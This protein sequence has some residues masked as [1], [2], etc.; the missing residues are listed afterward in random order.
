MFETSD[1]NK[2]VTPLV[3]VDLVIPVDFESF[4]GFE[5][6]LA[7]VESNAVPFAAV[8]PLQKGGWFFPPQSINKFRFEQLGK[9]ADLHRFSFAM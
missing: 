1:N 3:R 5:K 2:L 9:S 6:V 7:A 8:V 4:A